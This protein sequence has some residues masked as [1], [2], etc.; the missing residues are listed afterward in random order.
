MT[1]HTIMCVRGANDQGLQPH[2]ED[3]WTKK[4]RIEATTAHSR[5][6]G[7]ESID[8]DYHHYHSLCRFLSVIFIY[9]EIKLTQF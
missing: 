7:D 6:P 8:S 5:S 1:K 4:D 2:T 9:R 3:T